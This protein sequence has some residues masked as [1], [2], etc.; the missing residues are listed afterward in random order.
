[1]V[2]KNEIFVK[3][4]I[5]QSE[6]AI[7]KILEKTGNAFETMETCIEALGSDF[8]SLSLYEFKA[9][10][11]NCHAK[12][13]SKAEVKDDF[14]EDIKYIDNFITKI[15]PLGGTPNMMQQASSARDYLEDRK[16]FWSQQRVGRNKH[17]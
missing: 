16:E 4:G 11:T 10:L 8:L 17:S 12:D 2:T 3:D 13:R 9:S 5:Q 7:K 14:D 15:T 6:E 1:M